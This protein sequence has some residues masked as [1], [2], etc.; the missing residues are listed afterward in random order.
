MPAASPLPT[1][2]A[3]P[4]RARRLSWLNALFL[5][6]ALAAC[7]GGGGSDGGT[8]GMRLQAD[9]T[10]PATSAPGAPQATG[11]TANDGVTWTNYRRQQL[12]LGTLARNA[13]IDEAAQGHSDY[14]RIND[15]I[16]HEQTAGQ[17][18]FTGATLLDRLTAAGYQFRQPNYAF[19][20][21]ISATSSTSGFS[22]VED[23]I[24]A[25][26]HRFV[27]FEPRFRE[28]GAGA[29][30]VPNGFT[31]MTLNFAA[32]GLG[33]GLGRGQFA[34]Y[35]IP[36]QT[37]IVPVFYSDF[38]MPDPVGDRNEVGYPVS[39]HADIT[40]TVSVASF[41]IRPR[42]G[43]ALSTKLLTRATD[44]FTPSSV[45]AIVPLA[46]LLPNTTYEVA[47]SGTVD[48]VAAARNWSFT[49]R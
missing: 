7:G 27:I 6:F 32:D 29:G 49:T 16:T 38:E 30:T 11:N 23:L 20:E 47:F 36:D 4:S 37:G 12:G 31:Y 21:V 28:I 35:P 5:A 1:R 9:E 42:G 18:G 3:L 17:R 40:S 14:Q 13:D 19:G 45:A 48:G 41:T 10:A 24:T 25:I 8:S 46:P 22:A 44:S 15:V 2:L 39:V 43:A 33:A 26:Y 34:L